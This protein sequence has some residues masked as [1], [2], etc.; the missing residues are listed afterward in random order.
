[1]EGM[2][3]QR[4]RIQGVVSRTML[5]VLTMLATAAATAGTARGEYLAVY[6]TAGGQLKELIGDKLMTIDSLVV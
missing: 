4:G 3:K 2:R 1:M 5:T 6:P